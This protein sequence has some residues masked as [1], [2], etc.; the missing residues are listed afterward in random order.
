MI[1]FAHEV[2]LNEFIFHYLF[3]IMGLI[4]AAWDLLVCDFSISQLKIVM[5][6][7]VSVCVFCGIELFIASKTSR[8]DLG[9]ANWRSLFW[10]TYCC[11]AL[12]TNFSAAR[13][14]IQLSGAEFQ[15][16]CRILQQPCHRYGHAVA[17]VL[18]RQKITQS[19]W[20]R[21]SDWMLCVSNICCYNDINILN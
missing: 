16:V 9:R 5:Q 21:W 20:S 18:D 14:F 10:S 13:S 4:V 7:L 15:W 8:S 3:S 1:K 6:Y 11:Q 17:A 2:T 12:S 19:Y